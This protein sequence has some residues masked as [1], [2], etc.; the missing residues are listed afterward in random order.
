MTKNIVINEQGA[1]IPISISETDEGFVID[2]DGVKWCKTENRVH[3]SV[4]FNMMAEHI[5]EYMHY[6]KK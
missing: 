5:T 6:E 3:A 2:I 1:T 4:L